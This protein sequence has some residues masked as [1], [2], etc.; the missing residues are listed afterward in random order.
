MDGVGVWKE[1]E[2]GFAVD[3]SELIAGA[4]AQQQKK[5]VAEAEQTPA[6][7]PLTWRVTPEQ[8]ARIN[9]CDRAAIDEF[10]FDAGNFKRLSCSAWSFLRH[11]PSFRVVI[12]AEDLLQQVY[13]D[14]ITGFIKFRPFDTA[15]S[16]A[17][18]KSFRFAAV[19]G[20]DEV[21]IYKERKKCQKQAS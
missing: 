1:A 10:Y 3:L 19:G 9:I 20:L 11:N 14:L 4:Q 18:F 12:S 2:S 8:V 6:G 21:A 5:A 7:A 15:I 13:C 17:V 16:W